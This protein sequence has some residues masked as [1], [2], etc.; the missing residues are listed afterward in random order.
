MKKF[1]PLAL[2]AA[3]A[4][5]AVLAAPPSTVNAK[6]TL[7]S[8]AE[9]SVT[10]DAALERSRLLA[11]ERGETFLR[12]ALVGQRAPQTERLPMNVVVVIDRSG[13][14]SGRSPTGSEKMADARQAAKFLVDQLADGDKVA[15]VSFDNG[16]EVLSEARVI[17][18]GVAREIARRIDTLH[19]RGGTDMV[20]GLNVGL[21][22]AS[23][24]M[25]RDQVNRI[26]LIS[27]GLPNT[28]E[29]LQDISRRAAGKGITV[30][31][32][33]VGTDYNENLMSR[34]ADAGQGN[35]YFIRDS[36]RMATIFGEE[37][38][39]MMAVVAREAVLKI[40]LKN[41]VRVEE[42][43]GYEASTGRSEAAI[44]IGDILGGR[45]SEVLARLS[46]PASSGNT[47]LVNVTLAYH[48][49]LANT[50]RTA[51]TAVA[52]SFV[53]DREQVAASLNKDVAEKVEKVKVATAVNKAMEEYKKGNADKAQ[54]ILRAQ[55][56]ATAQANAYIG[57]ASLS[58]EL[59]QM[60]ALEDSTRA[61][62]DAPTQSAVQKS[63]KAR[64]RVL[65]R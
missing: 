63:A 2:V 59:Q 42:V 43:F 18:A 56:A 44:P 11:G 48:D 27:D 34:I 49:A 60:D 36:A 8:P 64:A 51:T 46:F 10:M 22:Q 40:A 47:E 21:E 16:A 57:S 9:G 4:L 30:T 53:A 62:A 50:G 14:M 15:I 38:K 32:M 39:S 28:E 17:G 25:R 35:Y 7:G 61:D 37:L 58:S 33:G 19:A 45:S 31:T 5:L 6:T 20:S 13:S 24:L 52:A 1:A 12:I 29:G 54:G 65:S 26:I 3:T 23:S 41:G 55:N